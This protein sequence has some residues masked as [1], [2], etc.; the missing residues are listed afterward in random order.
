MSHKNLRRINICQASCILVRRPAA[1]GV[2]A[3]RGGEGGLLA[4]DEGAER[5]NL[6]NLTAPLHRDLIHHIFHLLRRHS[7]HHDSS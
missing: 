5:R 6:L 3:E 2:E 4:R 1:G 7:C